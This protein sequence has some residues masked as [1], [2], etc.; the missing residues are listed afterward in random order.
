MKPLLWV[1]SSLQELRSF[2][3]DVRRIAGHQLHLVQ[4]SLE[5]H[6]WKAMTAVGPGVCE[7]RI[8]TETEHRVFYLA[9]FAEGVY[10]LHALQKKTQK[11]PRQDLELVRARYREIL[12]I[13]RR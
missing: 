1:G 5:P 2:P 8:H 6:D 4:Q 3:E 9:R 13:R 11:T 7:L 12:R 10:V